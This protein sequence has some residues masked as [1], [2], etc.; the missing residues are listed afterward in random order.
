MTKS[1]T[2]IIQQQ[3]SIDVNSQENTQNQIENFSDDENFI[4]FFFVTQ[5]F[6]SAKCH[7]VTIYVLRFPLDVSF[8]T[9]RRA[10]NKSVLCYVFF[11]T[12]Q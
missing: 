6:D 1:P 12:V 4:S 9:E 5:T 2:N 11:K 3:R 7:K 8:S 10:K